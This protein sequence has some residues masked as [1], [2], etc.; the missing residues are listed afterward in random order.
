MNF[1]S[2]KSWKAHPLFCQIH[3]WI[4]QISNFSIRMKLSLIFLTRKILDKLVKINNLKNKRHKKKIN[5]L[6]KKKNLK[7]KGKKRKKNV[8]NCR[9]LKRKTSIY[10]KF[11]NKKSS[12]KLKSK[13]RSKSILWNRRN[14][15]L[16]MS[17]WHLKALR[18]FNSK[19]NN[20]LVTNF[21]KTTQISNS[22][23]K[24]SSKVRMKMLNTLMSSTMNSWRST[25]S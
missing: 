25:R 4:C 15:Y 10:F 13:N 1:K 17:L 24:Y 16:L 6:K 2:L 22:Y 18:T 21:T 11:S 9:H 14:C 19:K 5:K 20:K 3:L 23:V 7:M 12:N 8:R